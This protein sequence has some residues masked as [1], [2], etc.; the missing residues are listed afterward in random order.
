[1]ST[2]LLDVD[3]FCHILCCPSTLSLTSVGHSFRSLKMFRECLLITSLLS[4]PLT[5][6]AKQLPCNGKIPRP[7]CFGTEITALRAKEVRG[8][9][10][11]GP[12]AGRLGIPFQ[13]RPIDFCNVTVSY[14]PWPRRQCQ[15][16]YLDATGRLERELLRPRWRRMGCWQRR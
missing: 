1:L 12:F 11:W 7:E 5:A 9:D 4:L 3:I 10:Q 15:C 14:T 2:T 6:T 16:L 8:W 13:Q